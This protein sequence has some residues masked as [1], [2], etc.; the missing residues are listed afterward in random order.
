MVTMVEEIPLLG[1]VEYKIH[2]CGGAG[3]GEGGTTSGDINDVDSQQYFGG[4][5]GDGLYKATINGTDYN[6]KQYFGL[7][8][9][10]ESDGY[11][12]IGAGG[13][14]G[15]GGEGGGFVTGFGNGGKGG[16]G[17]GGRPRHYGNPNYNGTDA[18]S[19]G[20]GGGGAGGGGDG[21]YRVEAMVVQ[22]L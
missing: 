18:I 9:E 16:G 6:F 15:Q 21:E 2:A 20:S 1:G 10:L 19:Y 13:G 5:G 3:I 4:K 11:Y 22:V 17:D 8:G 14:G 12:Y 7:N